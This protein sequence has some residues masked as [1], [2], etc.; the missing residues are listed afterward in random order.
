MYESRRTFGYQHFYIEKEA[1]FSLPNEG[2]WG[3]PSSTINYNTKYD[4][5]VGKYFT[6]LDVQP[7]SKQNEFSY[8]KNDWWFKLQNKD[9]ADEIVW[10]KYQADNEHKFP[11]ITVSYFNYVKK[12]LIGKKYVFKYY[13]NEGKVNELLIDNTDFFTGLTFVESKN[14]RWECIDI[15]IEDEY[16]KL[17]ALLRNQAGNVVSMPIEELFLQKDSSKAVYFFE[18][19][20]YNSLVSKWGER[21]MDNVRKGVICVGMPQSLLLLSWGKPDRINS[22]SYGPD[23]Y[24]YGN[25][26]VYVENGIIKAWN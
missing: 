16:Y 26:Y 22:S 2:H 4:N 20:K 5:L 6:V 17:V 18:V 10:F 24:V 19:S 12:S 13:I 15:T 7:D 21:Y 25:Q 3:E 14:N 11:F 9:K 23:Q 1:S 8:K